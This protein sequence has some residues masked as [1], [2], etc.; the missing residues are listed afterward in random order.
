LCQLISRP[1]YP[2]T[3]DEFLCSPCIGEPRKNGFAQI[4]S[5][6][7]IE[8]I[9]EKNCSHNLKLCGFVGEERNLSCERGVSSFSF[10]F[11]LE[12][13]L[14]CSE[15]GT[16]DTEIF[17]QR[18]LSR[19]LTFGLSLRRRS[20]WCRGIGTCLRSQNDN[21]Y[22]CRHR[23]NLCK[24]R[25]YGLKLCPHNHPCTVKTVPTN[26]FPQIGQDKGTYFSVNSKFKKERR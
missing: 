13:S 26:F 10:R 15:I 8:G 23:F 1:A 24:S 16:T 25:E 2:A 6:P 7:T 12:N 22:H 9:N 19:S 17:P 20:P 3:R 18:G 5:V 4:E 14:I 21:I 11:P